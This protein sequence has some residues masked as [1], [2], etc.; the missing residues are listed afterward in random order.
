MTAA[1]AVAAV[2]KVKMNVVLN[3]CELDHGE[4]VRTMA[5]R[6]TRS[7][8]IQAV[9]TTLGLPAALRRSAKARII[10]LNRDADRAAMKST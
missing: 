7:L 6:I 5:L 1:V 3:Y 2:F 8:R 4:L 9:M 10:G